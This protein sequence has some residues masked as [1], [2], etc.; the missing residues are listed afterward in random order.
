MERLHALA[1]VGGRV[2]LD[3]E[4]GHACHGDQIGAGRRGEAVARCGGFEPSVGR[5]VVAS[6]GDGE[7][8]FDAVAAAGGEVRQRRRAGHRAPQKLDA[9]LGS[10]S[11]SVEMRV[12]VPVADLEEAAG[13]QVRPSG[14]Q[15]IKA[16]ALAL[17]SE[18]ARQRKL[19]HHTAA[20]ERFEAGGLAPA[21]ETGAGAAVE[22]LDLVAAARA[23]A[24]ARVFEEQTAVL[25][26]AGR[27]ER[28]G[29]GAPLAGGGDNQIGPFRQGPAG[30]GAVP[31][32][33]REALGLLH[34]TAFGCARQV[35]GGERRSGVRGRERAVPELARLLG[36]LDIGQNRGP[37]RLVGIA[38]V[39]A[40]ERVAGA[41]P[42]DRAP[43]FHR[44][45]VIGQAGEIEGLGHGGGLAAQSGALRAERLRVGGHGRR[46]GRVEIEP[47][48]FASG[49]KDGHARLVV[50][51]DLVAAVGQ[52]DGEVAAGVGLDRG[53]KAGASGDENGGAAGDGDGALQETRC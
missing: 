26:G 34:Q 38:G 47:G 39:H 3:G 2:E 24:A 21:G 35:R 28:N 4:R 17:A 1:R 27:G 33:G 50:H 30:L 14:L 22:R 18:T 40:V 12:R 52:C 13:Q 25:L 7:N 37:S 16:V 5:D 10:A 29:L 9:A 15:E 19:R 44:E 49:H 6:G 41:S 42:R 36:S 20:R 43:R 45:A 23:D 53:A 11:G 8:A 51:G 48:R 32:E 31:R 46:W